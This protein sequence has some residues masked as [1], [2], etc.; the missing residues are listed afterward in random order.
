MT[1]GCRLSQKGCRGV[2]RHLRLS[3]RHSWQALREPGGHGDRHQ[4][5]AHHKSSSPET[6]TTEKID[7]FDS[8]GH[9]R[10]IRQ[11]GRVQFLP[12]CRPYRTCGR[13]GPFGSDG[14]E[15][16]IPPLGRCAYLQPWSGSRL[17]P[18][19]QSDRDSSTP[20]MSN[21]TETLRIICAPHARWRELEQNLTE[22]N[23]PGIPIRRQ[24]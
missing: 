1:I 18:P 7:F 10:Q 6:S 5:R 13:A 17:A 9:E 24:I 21:A 19:P 8:I 2:L 20:A 4:A 22:L 15:P 14:P 12:L 16:D 11:A 3:R 23:R